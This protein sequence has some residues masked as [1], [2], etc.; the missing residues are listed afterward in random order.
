MPELKDIMQEIKI[1]FPFF[2]DI[3]AGSSVI[4]DTKRGKQRG[5]DENQRCD[6][7]IRR[8]VAHIALL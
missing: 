1:Y 7:E 4:L 5:I 8:L 6:G 2:V 3:D